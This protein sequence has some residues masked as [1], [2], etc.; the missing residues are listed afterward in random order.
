M[1]AK[2]RFQ[3]AKRDICGGD[4]HNPENIDWNSPSLVATVILMGCCIIAEAIV[5][6]NKD[7]MQALRSDLSE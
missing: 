2:A 4:G 1:E 3:A 7:L 6:S 5:N